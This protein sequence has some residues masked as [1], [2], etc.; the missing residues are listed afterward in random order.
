[1]RR[2]PLRWLLPAGLLLVLAAA[3]WLAGSAWLLRQL[4]P[5]QDLQGHLLTEL[6]AASLQAGA[7]ASGDALA[8]PPAW[9]VEGLRWQWQG[10]RQGSVVGSLQVRRLVLHSA[11]GGPPPTEAELLRLLQGPFGLRL[12]PLRIERLEWNGQWLGAVQVDA[13]GLAEPAQAV[14][15]DGLRLERDRLRLQARARLAHDGALQLQL[16]AQTAMQT[17]GERAGEG[18]G[19]GGVESAVEGAVEN[20]QAEGSGSLRELSLGLRLQGRAQARAELRLAPLASQPLRSASA[21]FERLDPRAWAAEAPRGAWSGRLQ[22][23]ALDDGL[24]RIELGA[25]NA[26][27]LRLDEDGW[28]LRAL[29][30]QL[31]L[32]PAQWQQLELQRLELELGSAGQSAGRLALQPQR[33]LPQPGKPWRAEL[34]LGG[35]RSERLHAAWP[36]QVLSGRLS[37]SQAQWGAPQQPLSL[38]LA[39]RGADWR[40]GAQAEV[41]GRALQG[42]EARL[43]RG[44]AR[45]QASGSFDAGHSEG[46]QAQLQAQVSNLALPVALAGRS[47]SALLHGGLK[48]ELTQGARSAQG[49]IELQ[50]DPGSQLL[51]LALSGQARWQDGVWRAQLRA[52]DGGVDELELQ[53][54]RPVARLAELGQVQ[55]W[56]PTQARW[57][58][59]AL[60]RLQPLLPES[61]VALQG[62]TQGEW[63]QD[64]AL[65]A[66]ADDLQL[67]LRGEQGPWRLGHLSLDW[68]GRE[69]RMGL[70]E[71]EARGWQAHNLQASWVGG[72]LQLDGR[73]EMPPWP[74][75]RRPQDWRVQSEAQRAEDGLN[76]QLAHLRFG[77]DDATETPWLNVQGGRLRW[78]DGQLDG[79]G[80]EGARWEL[81]GEALQ[82]Q[83]LQVSR[84]AARLSLTGRPRL[85]AW[86]DAIDPR[87]RWRGDAR[88]ALALDLDWQGGQPDL[89]LRVAELQGDL[90]LDGEAMRLSRL[91][92]DLQRR[93]AQGTQARLWL[94]SEL[95]GRLQAELG[96]QAGGGALH[97]ELNAQMPQLRA[98]QAWWPQVVAEGE[99]SVSAQ[100]SGSVAQPR[101]DGELSLQLARLSHPGSGVAMQALRLR[102]GFDADRVRIRELRAEGAGE[103]GG[104]LTGEGEAQ[105]VQPWRADLR[106]R[107][108]RLRLLKRFD[109]RL[110]LSGQAALAVQAQR[111]RLRGDFAVDE[112]Q[113]ELGGGDAP[114]LDADVTLREPDTEAVSRDADASQTQR[115]IELKLELGERLRV[116]GRGF[117]SRLTGG[118]QY[119]EQGGRR[120]HWS[121]RVTT[122][123]GRYK[124]YGQTLDLET[125][126]LRFNG[127]LD[128]PA[129]ALLAIRP[130]VE[131]RVGVQ[132]SGSAQAPRARLFSEPELP[133]N[134][135]LAWLLLG[136]DPADLPSR[137][138]A[139]LQ[140]AA[141]ALLAGEGENPAGQ[142]MDSLGLT[143]LSLSPDAQD[144]TVLRVG[145][146]LGRRWSLGYERSLNAATGSWQLI[147]RI[148]QRFRLRAQSGDDNAIDLLWLWRFD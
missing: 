20:L 43:E 125:G 115:D 106:L 93:A 54:A 33:G 17:Q 85:A 133:D 7:E 63:R 24:L 8:A 22:V 148:G 66:R 92:L 36:A 47:G 42:L 6:R 13:L 96:S 121:G 117:A 9:R 102:A 74:G 140:R 84:T 1:V 11:A 37:L 100:L 107:A 16:Q 90:S 27:A 53:G 32:R 103:G 52:G 82:L 51:G 2:A 144:G 123:G 31:A 71:A 28:P 122:Q 83:R 138:T 94:E 81:L 111:L 34:D 142:L 147:Y 98:L 126:E 48:A 136:R 137:D 143:E 139:L 86:I 50:L 69:G 77:P 130:G 35:L 118:L 59:A 29:Q 109:R 97:G 3:L 91:E 104:L 14:L 127:A 56:W 112:G 119:V 110:T 45:L 135:V 18:G 80:G 113:F 76:W 141:L 105:W 30:L 101:V 19:E 12:A 55:S 128:N 131:H 89:R 72:R 10:L 62:A 79:Q 23:D 87:A 65:H 134:D 15:L 78:Q 67:R 99:A 116:Q 25:Q 60:Q 124:A 64:G 40:L 70:R 88:A 129:I 114:A 44:A 75:R 132:V 38:T 26:L 58:V 5:A 46:W 68:D 57:S 41:F 145:A 146:Q 120:P 39:L 49:R 73:G 61:I 95:L 108:E 21:R 4:L